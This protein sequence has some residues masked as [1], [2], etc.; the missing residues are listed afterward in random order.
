MRWERF[1]T[2]V[3]LFLMPFVWLGFVLP[4]AI[5]SYWCL[6]RPGEYRVKWFQYEAGQY[7]AT[8]Q[9]VATGVFCLMSF[10]G[11]RGECR[12]TDILVI[13]LGGRFCIKPF[14][15]PQSP[16]DTKFDQK[17]KTRR[18]AAKQLV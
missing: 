15:L 1:L 2:V 17:A 10:P 14:Y 12:V 8:V 9:C 11:K 6:P 13:S 16:A 5:V 4:A 7:V 3:G 18:L